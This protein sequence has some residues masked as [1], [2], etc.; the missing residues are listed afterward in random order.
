[1]NKVISTQSRVFM[2]M[3]GPSGSG[4]SFLIYQMLLNGTFVP[5]FDK[6]LYFY[7]HFQSLYNEMTSQIPNIEFINNV[8]F[9]MINSLPNDG[10]N[11][12]II[13][14]DSCEEITKNKEF[15]KLATAGRHRKLSCIY[16]KHNLFH[17]SPIGRDAE[18][19]NTHIVL[20]KSP[21]DVQQIKILAR[22]LGLGDQLVQWYNHATN[23]PYGHLM[24]DLDPKT[25]DLLRYSTESTSFPAK[26][27][28]PN[29][30]ARTT[31]IDD[32]QTEL[33]YTKALSR[34][35]TKPPENCPPALF[36]GIH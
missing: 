5:L 1:M 33:L 35:Q 15:E 34:I 10:C 26:Y 17:K 8:D 23:K 16:V 29:S 25:P 19:Q 27:F 18:L 3:V 30:K 28:V 13:F 12:L 11:Y 32:Q 21:R 36:Q 22:Q 2:S 24:I 14:D 6:V 7:Q 4:K 9:E 20:F 31:F